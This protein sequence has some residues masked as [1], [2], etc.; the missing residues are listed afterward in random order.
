MKKHFKRWTIA[1]MLIFIV[2]LTDVSN[3][4]TETKSKYEPSVINLTNWEFESDGIYSLK[5]NWEFYPNRIIL[6]EDFKKQNNL[7]IMHLISVPGAF[8]NQQKFE[9]QYKS[10]YGTLRTI[11]KIPSQYIGQKLAIR[12]TLFY[13]DTE[14]YADGH[15]LTKDKEIVQRSSFA[16]RITPNL[17]ISF[18]P[19]SENVELI[20]NFTRSNHY[21]SGYGNV[22]LGLSEQVQ[23]YIVKWL[24]IDT[25]LFSLMLILAIFNMGFFLRVNSRKSK[26]WLALYFA[27]LVAI[28]LVRIINSGDQY[29]LYL[30]P[31]IP[32]ELFNKLNYWSYYL[33]LPIFILF[34]CEVRKD[35]LPP[36][37]KQISL[38]VI[39]FFGLMV[40]M[41]GENIYARLVPLYYAYFVTILLLL[42]LHMVRMARI[43][44]AWLKIELVAFSL[45]VV[46]FIL[47]SL[48][49][50][51]YYEIRNYYLA[52]ITFF[53]CYVTFM[54]SKFYSRSVDRLEN[55]TF[56]YDV[57]EKK[58]IQS[59]QGFEEN[60]FDIQSEFKDLLQ[61][62]ELH[63]DA[64]KEVVR[65]IEV[66]LVILDSQLKIVS[67]YGHDMEKHFGTHFS[68]E[69][70][71]KYFFGES[72][73][74]G[75]L[76]TD[77]MLRVAQLKNPERAITY[78]SLLPKLIYKQGRW[79]KITVSLIES[80][81]EENKQF[82]LM[83]NDVSKLIVTKEQSQKSQNEVK[84]LKAHIKFEKELKY[85]IFRT[86]QFVTLNLPEIIKK[87]QNV[88]ELSQILS[89]SLERFAI[90]YEAMGFDHT[91]GEFRKFIFDLK[92]L[93]NDNVPI[94]FEKMVQMV[95]SR[96]IGDF[97][98]EDQQVLSH[99]IGKEIRATKKE[100]EEIENQSQG[101]FEMFE[102]L[103]PYCKVL[104]DRYGKTVEPLKIEGQNI[105]LPLRKMGPIL[106]ELSR[107]FDAIIVHNI[108]YVDERK[109]A[110]KPLT[111]H[112]EV[113]IHTTL[114]HLV[115]D[116][117]DD[118]AGINI[119][120]LKDSMYKLDLMSFKEI[121]S[122]SEE[123]VLP[124]IFSQG[125]YYKESDNE[126]D[127]IG[128]GLWRVKEALACING[129]IDVKSNYQSYCKF[130][131]RIPLEE[132][133]E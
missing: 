123:E 97:D 37:I 7:G 90:W 100:L 4:C 81:N 38:Y 64:L 6:H 40:L 30:I 53:I 55:L 117:Q 18:V 99:Y 122:A 46:I 25:F 19:Q 73:D 82:V 66:T 22:I 44:A 128:D 15:Q 27:M 94:T 86:E 51:G 85:L 59:N 58:M 103:Q 116:I 89:I 70:F 93:S 1:F 102:I 34:A 95:E 54:V 114:T 115:I 101:I 133:C 108:E 39:M 61:E 35:M 31:K 56:E 8:Y 10:N 96:K 121:V 17:L 127:G 48:Y 67:I 74:L 28:M 130:T 98:L 84:M 45:M 3:Y 131:V 12:S 69:K 20:I 78:L 132:I 29:L 62:K 105:H 88:N 111:A 50:L 11:I 129:T 104:I 91:Y 5:E 110:N 92:D 83:I 107:I 87:A 49:I 126:Y 23:D 120:T 119:N 79:Y 16:N 60:I 112:I 72:S 113:Q 14:V 2:S 24:I 41:L 36:F 65:D 47:D 68:G 80:A 26:E 118:G 76:F 77:I 63:L 125:V 109:R 71:V 13:M 43:G 21:G 33:L 57:L 9:E 124:F 32:G 52:G 106:R 75:Q 42:T